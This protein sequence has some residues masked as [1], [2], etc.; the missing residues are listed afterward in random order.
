[1]RLRSAGLSCHVRRLLYQLNENC[2]A[3]AQCRHCRK[4]ELDL[5]RGGKQ[6]RPLSGLVFAFVIEPLLKALKVIQ[7]VP[8]CIHRAFAG[9]IA[10]ASQNVRA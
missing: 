9:D 7:A 8:E 5:G 10:S 3:E 4:V 1:M 6:G 2:V